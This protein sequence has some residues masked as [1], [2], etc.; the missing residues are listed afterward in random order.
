MLKLS[1][2]REGSTLNLAG[3]I[4]FNTVI[5]VLKVDIFSN[6]KGKDGEDPIT[7]DFSGVKSADSSGLALMVHWMRNAKR[8]NSSVTF[9]NIPE[10]LIALA[11]MSNLETV[12]PLSHG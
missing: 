2:E 7:I 4:N 8:K 12:L 11:E 1:I 5:D 3:D 9:A 6:Q 10:K